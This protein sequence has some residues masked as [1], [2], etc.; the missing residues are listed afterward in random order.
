ML[1]KV[2]DASSRCQ[3]VGEFPYSKVLRVPNCRPVAESKVKS[4]FEMTLQVK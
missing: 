1:N 3:E 4:S 2:G